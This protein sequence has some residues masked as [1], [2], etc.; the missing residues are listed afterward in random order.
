MG[1]GVAL[2]L[3]GAVVTYLAVS[4]PEMP[5]DEREEFHR[6]GGL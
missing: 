4:Q 5:E 6:G 2:I 1:L 3:L